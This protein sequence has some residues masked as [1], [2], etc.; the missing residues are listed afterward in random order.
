MS[1]D[2][3]MVP[4]CGNTYRVLDRVTHI[5]NEKT[6]KMQHLKNDCIMLDEVVCL[7]CYAKYRRFCPRSIHPYWREIWLE[8]A[9]TNCP[10]AAEHTESRVPAHVSN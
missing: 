7:A 3:E 6:G 10:N 4:F 2:P 8:R 5:I 9:A 1:F